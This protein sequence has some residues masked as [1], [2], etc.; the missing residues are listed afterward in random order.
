ML[1]VWTDLVIWIGRSIGETGKLVWGFTFGM[2]GGF[3]IPVFVYAI[4]IG[5]TM[6]VVGSR[7]NYKRLFVALPF[8]TLPLAFTYHLSHNLNHLAREG[9]GILELF[10]NPLGNGLRPITGIERHAQM[11]NRV[12]EELLFTMQAGLMI[13]G[14]WLAVHILR[15]RAAKLLPNNENIKGWQ[16][17]PMLVF[18]VVIAGANVW[19]LSQDMVMRF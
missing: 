15:H 16:L 8:S 9:G 13:M 14:V 4:A 6:Y 7:I 10:F 18:I 2:I 12:P 19:L 5:A 17:A 1:P 11:M 3:A